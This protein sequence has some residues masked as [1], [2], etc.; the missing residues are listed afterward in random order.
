[1]RQWLFWSALALL[2]GALALA[3]A[4][5]LRNAPPAPPRAQ[6]A[7]TDIL[8]AG[9]TTGFAAADAPRQFAF[10]AD[11]GPHPGF[12]NEWWYFTGNLA[13]ADGR[14]FGFQLTFFRSALRPPLAALF[15]PTGPSAWHADQ[16]YMGQFA[17]TDP[18]GNRFIA[19]DRFSRA[20]VGLAGAQAT[21]F[22]VWLDDWSAEAAL[23][24]AP[25]EARADAP[26]QG[27][28]KLGPIRLRATQPSAAGPVAIDLTLRAL[29]PPTLQGDQGLSR[30]GPDPGQ[31]SYYY[32]LPRMETHGSVQIGT[33]TFAVTGLSWMDREWSTSALSHGE[34]GWDWFSVQ[35]ADG[36]DLM[37]YRLRHADGSFDPV[38]RGTITAA[39]GTVTQLL[40]GAIQIDVLA[41]WRSPHSGGVYPSRW[42]LRAPAQNIDLTITPLRADQELNLYVTYWEGAVRAE[43]TGGD[44]T[45]SAPA[46]FG[47]V[48]LTGYAPAPPSA[49]GQ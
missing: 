18:V 39:D 41:T 35:L 36:R 31:A 19:S 28:D 6:V 33:E 37:Y 3:A 32:S 27:P 5:L 30:K 49:Q 1:M 22:R 14:R 9:P 45:H 13:T 20:A 7:V 29:K 43:S 26:G 48:E 40:P 21:P 15:E 23:K 16:L 34:V 2:A 47:Y 44:G 24:V 25:A 17:L 10:P 12:R 38:S 42:R 11:H 4:L 46:G 8:G